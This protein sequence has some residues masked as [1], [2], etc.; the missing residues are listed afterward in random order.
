MHCLPSCPQINVTHSGMNQMMAI[1]CYIGK[2][3]GRFDWL[4][5]RNSRYWYHKIWN[6]SY[7]NSHFLSQFKMKWSLYQHICLSAFVCYW[8]LLITS[9]FENL[10]PNSHVEVSELTEKWKSFL[11]GKPNYYWSVS[12]AFTVRL[13][14]QH[15]AKIECT[16]MQSIRLC[17]RQLCVDCQCRRY[18]LL[19]YSLH[20][21]CNSIQNHISYYKFIA[22]HCAHYT[23]THT[24]MQLSLLLNM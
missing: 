15:V 1:V 2:H 23:H 13:K 16:I 20:Y 11:E 19:L 14:A 22:R 12:R 5:T 21:C 18:W 4:V 9:S 17:D 24:C 10:K 6:T 8:C 7:L 3:V